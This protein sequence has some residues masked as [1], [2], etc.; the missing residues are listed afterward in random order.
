M[1]DYINRPGIT[2]QQM[3]GDTLGAFRQEM[4]ER[5]FD[6]E[7]PRVKER[8]ALHRMES[9]LSELAEKVVFAETISTQLSGGA[10][11]EGAAE[12]RSAQ[13]GLAGRINAQCD[14]LSGLTKRL[15]EALSVIAAVVDRIG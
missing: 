10:S 3:G 4:P 11:V 15:A 12:K 14:D 7:A 5:Q 1:Q 8:P 2:G 9:L 13:S 6:T